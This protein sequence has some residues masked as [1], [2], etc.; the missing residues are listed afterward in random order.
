MAI[1]EY[2]CGACGA[3]IEVTDR[4]RPIARIV[5]L[6]GDDELLIVPASVPFEAVRGKRFPPAR[7]SRSSLEL[8]L[9]ERGER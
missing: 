3:R 2:D 1:Y 6:D 9:E 8:L 4:S 5:P 7:W